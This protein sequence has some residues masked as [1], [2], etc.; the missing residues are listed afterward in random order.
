[1]ALFC[2]F[3]H[4]HIVDYAGDSVNT[5]AILFSDGPESGALDSLVARDP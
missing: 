4:V 2:L 3:L 1:M 5:H